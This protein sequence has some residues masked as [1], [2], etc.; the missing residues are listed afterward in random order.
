MGFYEKQDLARV[1]DSVEAR[2]IVLMGV[3]LGAAI[4]L[5]AAADDARIDAVVAAESFSDLRTIATERA[6]FFLPPAVVQAAFEAAERQARF[7]IDA[8]SPELAAA[9]IRVPVMLIH[10]ALDVETPPAHS[11]RIFAALGGPKKLM[12]VDGAGH[13]QSLTPAV[14]MEIERWLDA[15][16]PSAAALLQSY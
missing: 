13:N 12:I 14:W 2:P 7:T 4:A 8:V 9:R 10:G 1:L 6:P 5:Q 3:S 15:L 16:L 11:Q